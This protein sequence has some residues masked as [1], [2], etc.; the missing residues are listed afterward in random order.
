[1]RRNYDKFETAQ[2]TEDS[3]QSVLS[4]VQES[5]QAIEEQF[6]E[7]FFTQCSEMGWKE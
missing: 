4:P 3:E 7:H 6:G 1:M 5:N 2:R